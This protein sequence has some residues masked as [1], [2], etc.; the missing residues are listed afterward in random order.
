MDHLDPTCHLN[1]FTI[2]PLTIFHRPQW[3]RLDSVYINCIIPI[4]WRRK[5]WETSTPD[6][7]WSTW[8]CSNIT[9]LKP[10]ATLCTTRFNIQKVFF[11]PTQGNYILCVVLRTNSIF[12]KQAIYYSAS[13]LYMFRVS[14]TPIVRSTQNCNHGPRHRSHPL[15]SQL[16]PW[17]SLATLEGG[18]WTK[19]MTSTGGHSHSHMHNQWW[20]W[21]T[22]E[23]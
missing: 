18:N 21:L 11:L 4:R 14:T 9:H 16:P 15:C 2:S 5:V 3:W 10:T 23:K 6:A 17:Q 19:N 12:T 20:V 8:W 22:P 13:S 7:N 1:G